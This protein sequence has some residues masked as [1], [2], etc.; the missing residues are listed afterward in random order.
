MSFAIMLKTFQKPIVLNTSFRKQEWETILSLVP[1][2]IQ[3]IIEEHNISY[4]TCIVSLD[5]YDYYLTLVMDNVRM[6]IHDRFTNQ[7]TLRSLTYF[8]NVLNVKNIVVE[9]VHE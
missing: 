8:Q 4:N 1:D 5:R 9:H 6:I 3:L 2:K 7:T